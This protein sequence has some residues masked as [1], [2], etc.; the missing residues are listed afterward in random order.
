MDPNR[1]PE[2]D[3]VSHIGT[4]WARILVTRGKEEYS[5]TFYGRLSLEENYVHAI[6]SRNC[7]VDDDHERRLLGIVGKHL[8]G[9]QRLSFRALLLGL[10]DWHFPGLACSR[11]HDGK[12]RE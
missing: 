11:L 10:R 4:C 9:S 8:Q 6:K 2:E 12:Y 1:S 7:A 5:Y 3:R